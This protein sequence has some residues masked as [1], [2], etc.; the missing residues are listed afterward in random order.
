MS[1]GKIMRSGGKYYDGEDWVAR[2]ARINADDKWYSVIRTTKEVIPITFDGSGKITVGDDK[3]Y[4]SDNIDVRNF[5]KIEIMVRNKI[6][7]GSISLDLYGTLG[8]LSGMSNIAFFDWNED[9]WVGSFISDTSA[10]GA[11]IKIPERNNLI[12]LSTHPNLYWLKDNMFDKLRVRFK[13]DSTPTSGSEN[14]FE[15]WLVGETYD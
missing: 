4:T 12:M 2:G 14:T 9:D 7:S 5:S 1:D 13:A 11:Y 6:D 10:S 15:A 8:N 3:R